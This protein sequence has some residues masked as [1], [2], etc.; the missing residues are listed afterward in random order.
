MLPVLSMTARVGSG[1]AMLPG[2]VLVA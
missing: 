2:R 1:M